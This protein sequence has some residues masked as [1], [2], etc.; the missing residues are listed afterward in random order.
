MRILVLSNCALKESQGSGYVVLNY[1]RGLRARGHEIELFGPEHF[2][3]VPRLRRA[4]RYRQTIGMLGC[5][6]GQWLRKR[7]D[8]VEFYGAESCLAVSALAALRRRAP[9]LVGHTNG[10]ETFTDAQMTRYAGSAAPDGGRQRWLPSTRVLP[11]ERAFTR[12]DGMVTVSAAERRFALERGYQRPERVVA[13]DNPLPDDYLGQEI[14]LDRGRTIAYCGS[15]L[16]RKGSRLMEVAL[17]RVLAE[18]PDLD[19][20]LVGVGEQ[21]RAEAYFPPAVL[22]R[23]RVIPFVGSRDELRRLYHSSAILL[24]PSI[25][26]SF[27]MVT[28]EGMACGC[29]LVTTR[30]GFGN[31]LA[32]RLEALVLDEATPEALAEAI[33]TLVVD[34]ALRRQ[35]ARSGHRRV[36]GL[37][38]S[39]AV[40]QL[41][42]CYQTWL[43]ELQPCATS[44]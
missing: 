26:E 28:A 43:A 24:T 22:A 41:E 35:V 38:W 12:V 33:R 23:V 20:T 14:N 27:G 18:F 42:A 25:H 13:I 9:L 8:V 16:P 44:R 1:C 2:E 39:L 15:W 21:F 30:T 31:D 36:Q 3:P 32:H 6:L 5:T 10:F 37:R 40:A 19:L 17:P 29:A 11:V 4:K 34:E 7:F